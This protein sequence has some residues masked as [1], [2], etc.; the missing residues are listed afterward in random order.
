MSR[1]QGVVTD[2]HRPYPRWVTSGH[3]T[4][5]NSRFGVWRNLVPAPGFPFGTISRAAA[6]AARQSRAA[7]AALAAL[8][9]KTTA[10]LLAAALSRG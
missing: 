5:L 4:L 2:A 3:P 6:S 1:P 7:T 9:G 10:V 8:R